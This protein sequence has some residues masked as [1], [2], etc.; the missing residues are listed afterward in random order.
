MFSDGKDRLLI[1]GFFSRP[2]AWRLLLL[3]IG[4]DKKRIEQELGNR[5]PNVVAILTAHAH[6]DHALDTA[7]V[8]FKEQR[9]VVV[10][11]PSVAKLV[12]DRG[13]PHSR[14]CVPIDGKPMKFG[15]YTVT[16]YDVPHGPSSPFLK[17]ILDHPLT[18][19]L[20]GPAWFGSYKDDKNLSFLI[21]HGSQRI[22][23]NPS[24]EPV[25]GGAPVAQTVFLG[26]GRL[27]SMSDTEADAYWDGTVRTA[28]TTVI[29]I[30]WDRFTTP[31]GKPFGK[32]P[33]F[34]DDT[35]KGEGHVCR[36]ARSRRV[37]TVL[38]MDSL[39]TLVLRP[40]NPPSL[41]ARVTSFCAP[42]S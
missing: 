23:V 27:G 39:A 37:A 3:P 38:R 1:D 17:R 11:T 42:S 41:G 30:H 25:R 33:R 4:P 9:A 19:K 35:V 20:D 40:S 8:A 21:E 16:A 28:G 5:P 12:G 34:L 29:P 31:V 18:Q 2:S 10:G 32:S 24:A 6:H 15:P 22:F 26:I 36:L 13:T 14:T 7:A